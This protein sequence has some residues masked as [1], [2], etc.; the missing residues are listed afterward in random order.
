MQIRATFNSFI[1]IIKSDDLDKFALFQ[2]EHID[3]FHELITQKDEAHY[4]PLYYALMSGDMA[5]IDGIMSAL[6]HKINTEK[7]DYLKDLYSAA[8]D[9]S[10][11]E[12][13]TKLAKILDYKPKPII[14]AT[15]LGLSLEFMLVDIIYRLVRSNQLDQLKELKARFPTLW[16]TIINKA[17]Y[18]NG[19]GGDT[20]LILAAYD[21]HLEL[22]DW[23]LADDQV[24]KYAKGYNN[25][26]YIENLVVFLGP[27]E[28]AI[29]DPDIERMK[30]IFQYGV[31]WA[32][33]KNL[34][35][36]VE[37]SMESLI[38][39]Y[40]KSG[41]LTQLKL[42]R[43][44]IPNVFNEL[45]NQCLGKPDTFLT[46]AAYHG[47]LEIINWLIHECKVDVSV[48]DSF[49]LSYLQIL[50]L[51]AIRL[52][53]DKQFDKI[54]EIIACPGVTLT[55]KN[56]KGE[57]AEDALRYMMIEA[58]K[59]GDLILLKQVRNVLPV[60]FDK[61]MNKT[62]SHSTML[63]WA[64]YS[65][66][67]EVVDW[68]ID[69]CKADVSVKDCDGH[70]Y[71]Q[72]FDL[73]AINLA[74][75]SEFEKISSLLK[76]KTIT[77][78]TTL[79]GNKN[80]KSILLS[81]LMAAIKS[82]NH[83]RA[84]LFLHY[85]IAQFLGVDNPTLLCDAELLEQAIK[86]NDFEKY[87]SLIK[88]PLLLSQ[89][90]YGDSLTALAVALKYDRQHIANHLIHSGAKLGTIADM[91]YKPGSAKII[92]EY[93]NVSVGL[94]E[95][96]LK[97]DKR[98]QSKKD[99]LVKIKKEELK[100][101]Q[102]EKLDF[103]NSILCFF[104]KQHSEFN[105]DENPYTKMD[106]LILTNSI[107][108]AID[109][110]DTINELIQS[111]KLILVEHED[112]I[113]AANMDYCYNQ[114]SFANRLC[115]FIAKT[116]HP[117]LPCNQLLHKAVTEGRQ[118]PWYNP[119][120]FEEKTKH[121][122]PAK[123][124]FFRTQDNEIH[125]YGPVVESACARLNDGKALLSHIWFGTDDKVVRPVPPLFMES[126]TILKQRTPSLGYLVEY[127]KRLDEYT[128]LTSD[129]NVFKRFEL[130]VNGL[131]A[132][133]YRVTNDH[134]NAGAAAYAAIASFSEWW[135]KIVKT[136]PRLA[137]TIKNL[138][139]DRGSYYET[140]GSALDILFDQNNL[141][142]NARA[143][144]ANY[145]IHLKANI[146]DRILHDATVRRKLEAMQLKV[147]FEFFEFMSESSL[148]TLKDTI[149]KELEDAKF[150][151]VTIMTDNIGNFPSRALLEINVLLMKSNIIQQY[152][153]FLNG[154]NKNNDLRKIISYIFSEN[155]NNNLFKLRALLNQDTFDYLRKVEQQPLSI[156]K[157][158]YFAT[159]K[160]Q[161]TQTNQYYAKLEEALTAQLVKNATVSMDKPNEAALVVSK[162]YQENSFMACHRSYTYHWSSTNNEYL[163]LYSCGKTMNK[164]QADLT[165]KIEQVKSS[166]LK[167]S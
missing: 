115:E 106:L 7:Y 120:E 147:P 59:K 108:A 61:L 21:G 113:L 26:T 88:N 162:L 92:T 99:S 38:F 100:K 97:L 74:I 80:A 35:K 60:H 158:A 73:A 45:Q 50:D 103:S 17:I 6:A 69:E 104:E 161:R 130:L 31:T 148:T 57:T 64:A 29:D 124:Q 75:I 68:L 139:H 62:D 118:T 84:A 77:F 55:T 121:A 48:K 36:T 128:K 22:L 93:N 39:E 28:K 156:F 56:D 151:P 25:A 8:E 134:Q 53:N 142:S 81:S 16:K 123:D 41:N 111:L 13:F 153:D 66:N 51:T 86:D 160:G 1:E 154:K 4:R 18:K 149:L 137:Q 32:M 10:K 150:T 82:G 58:A 5:V 70:D 54:K 2:S 63:T 165:Q 164:I 42:M 14:Q 52:A 89:A 20:P 72:N 76:Y 11:K 47:Q 43:D 49:D 79:K 96:F 44:A 152:T 107:L 122:L 12:E 146:I 125:L 167:V 71:A 78:T 131:Y 87:K 119:M 9:L 90:V 65:A 40:I 105:R 23:L 83:E 116:I 132:G 114:T 129:F 135:N 37:S 33:V 155:D 15:S 94:S 27:L 85:K 136:S 67:V 46:T 110:T 101:S 95:L 140:I 145:C 159:I 3:Q 91:K 34:N 127:T 133:D 19:L 98:I 126:L 141:H 143:L 157:P 30:R 117:S 24:D 112:A 109:N 138:G 163:T 166:V 102:L 144:D